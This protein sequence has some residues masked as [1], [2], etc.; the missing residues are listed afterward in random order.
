MPPEEKPP[1]ELGV[2]VAGRIDSIDAAAAEEAVGRAVGFLQE[3]FDAY[4]WRVQIARRD[5]WTVDTPAEPTV[6][7][8]PARDARDEHGW[9]FA[10]VVTAADLVSH[11]KPYSFGVVSKAL[12]VAVLSTARV[13]PR[14]AD[15]DAPEEHRKRRMTDALLRILLYSVGHWLGLDPHADRANA[16][17]RFDPAL[18][19]GEPPELTR[20]Q[21]DEANRVLRD[22]A[23]QRLEESP[24]GAS[25]WLP[26]FYVRA[27]WLN[28]WVILDTLRRA[29]PWEFPLR[30]SRLTTAALSTAVV[31]LMTAE[32]WDMAM[33]QRWS[34]VAAL[35]VF[36]IVA[37]TAYVAVRQG[38]F[39]RRNGRRVT[40]Q[41]V[42]SNVTAASIVAAGML[43]MYAWLLLITFLG[44][45]LLFPSR[46]VTGW[47]ASLGGEP[48]LEHYCLM[49]ATVGCLG[50]LIGALGA[51]FERNTH[52]R[53]V[54]YVDEEV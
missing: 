38:L 2:V 16:M 23:D 9:D 54:I 40:E 37:T 42:T 30:L 19:P 24:G 11:Y 26:A 36:S 51:S 10:F 43:F 21:I 46:V 48:R 12:D 45:W 32:T 31:L 34:V 17:H 22:I 33:S 39:L 15:P 20:D 52:F 44:A 5:E 4:N 41:I 28:R 14:S 49:A 1:I 8:Q 27:V 53:H 18:E 47:A 35:L 13:D 3:R 50:I 7:L 29:R 25:K 6:L